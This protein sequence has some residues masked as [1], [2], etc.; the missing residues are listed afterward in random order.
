MVIMNDQARVP[1]KPFSAFGVKA[2]AEKCGGGL[3]VWS[4][5][6]ETAKV[7]IFASA[8]LKILWQ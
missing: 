6:Q 3:E 4:K 8:K 7:Q 5:G 1:K 2:L